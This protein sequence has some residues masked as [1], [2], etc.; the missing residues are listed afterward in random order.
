MG[1]SDRPE[2]KEIV[3][4]LT[5][6]VEILFSELER[7]ISLYNRK[8]PRKIQKINLTGGGSNLKGL[9]EKPKPQDAPSDIATI[10]C[11]ILPPE[12]FGIIEN[13]KPSK[14]GE[15]IL[16]GAIDILA[17]Q[18]PIY[19]REIENAK[20]YDCGDKLSY[21]IANLDFAMKRPDL[22]PGLREYME[23]ILHSSLEAEKARSSDK[24]VK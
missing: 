19:I 10:G 15:Y 3:S 18:M 13:L 22:A 1:L 23:K 5:P 8:S 12:I 14:D 11:Y 24:I 7:L 4:V 2:E 16:A 6:L 20:Y 21:I 17:K 9:V